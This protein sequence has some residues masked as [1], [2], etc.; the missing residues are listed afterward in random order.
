MAAS[1]TSSIRCCL[2]FLCWYRY[3]FCF[4]SYTEDEVS[5]CLCTCRSGWE[6]ICVTLVTD[7]VLAACK[8]CTGFS[9][10]LQSFGMDEEHLI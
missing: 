8:Y 9:T 3:P 10:V 1:T 4:F 7:D 6:K 2:K 5:D